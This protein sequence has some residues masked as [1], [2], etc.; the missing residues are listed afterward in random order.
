MLRTVVYIRRSQE[1]KSEK[2]IQSIER[3][4]DALREFVETHNNAHPQQSDKLSVDWSKDVFR[5][6]QTAKKP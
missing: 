3:Q 6:E 1:E 4:E 2:Q 5:E